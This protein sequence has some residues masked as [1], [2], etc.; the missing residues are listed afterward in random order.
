MSRGLTQATQSD[1]QMDKSTES[2]RSMNVPS[3]SIFNRQP[4]FFGAFLWLCV[5]FACF[6]ILLTSCSSTDDPEEEQPPPPARPQIVGRIASIP[7]GHSFVLIQSYGDWKVSDGTILT[8]RGADQRTA[9]LLVTGEK[10]G[11]FAA[12]DIQAGDVAVGDTVLLLPTTPP[13]PTPEFTDDAPPTPEE[14]E[15]PG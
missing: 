15:S 5:K 14:G 3:P 12:A 1:V 4:L 13:R 10:L 8:T 9:N 6:V 11:Q 2:N 7:T